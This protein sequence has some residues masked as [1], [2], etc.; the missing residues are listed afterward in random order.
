MCRINEES[1]LASRMNSG[2]GTSLSDNL[3]YFIMWEKEDLEISL[4]DWISE[5]DDALKVQN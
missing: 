4:R 3:G 2:I 1:D 5:L